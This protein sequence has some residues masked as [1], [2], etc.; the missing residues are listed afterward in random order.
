MTAPV[1]THDVRMSSWSAVGLVASRELST[2]LRSKAYVIT[3]VVMLVL[4]IGVSLVVKLLSGGGADATVGFTGPTAELSAPLQASAKAIGERVATAA[5]ADEAAGR[6]KVSDG[7]LDALLV[8]DG[9]NI[10]VVVKK[11]LDGKLKNALDVL[12]GQLALNQQVIELG[13]DPA[14]VTVAVAGARAEVR[15]M[16][17]PYDYNKQQ[18]ALGII[19]GILIYLSLLMNGQIVAQGVVEEKTSRVV[20]LLLSTIRPWQL[21]A[22]KVLG[23]GTVGL[24]QMVVI[25]GAGVAFG[26][27]TG[28][29]TISF[30]T[31]VG[32]V[33]WLIVWYL[34]GFFMYS[35]VFAALGALVSRQEDVGGAIMP[36]LMVVIAGYIVGISVLP[37]DPGSALA[38]VLSV[39]PL[40]APTLM[41]MRLA[42]GGVP[43][44]EA[45][46]SVALVVALIPV[47]IW[48]AARIYRNAVLRTGAKVKLRDALKSA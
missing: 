39:I 32:T 42:M 15:P 4:I 37:A 33:A 17:Q 1:S 7:S 2:R 21:M 27:A 14:K 24:I 13:G 25:G 18:L 36:V 43:V 30:S 11:D 5:V 29:L 35:I 31:A 16:E 9:R 19:A 12:A 38:E 48:F 46:L 10:E 44:W 20:E 47:L 23:I 6:A 22:G 34:L 40:F 45:G 41:P 28:V 3:T 26:L 8:G